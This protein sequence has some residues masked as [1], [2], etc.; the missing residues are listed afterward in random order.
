M[1]VLGDKAGERYW[2]AFWQGER[3]PQAFRVRGG[4]GPRTWFYRQFHEIWK[5]H[6][7]LPRQGPVK[8]LEI[9]CA[10]S[11]WLVYFAR[12][13]GYT[14]AGLDYSAEGCLRTRALLEREGVAGEILHQDLFHPQPAHLAAF[15]VVFSNG[16]VEHF[17]DSAAVVARMA[18]YLRPAGLMITIVPNLTGWLGELQQQLSPEV[19]AVHT[20]L[21]REELA[22]AHQ[23]AGLRPLVCAYTAFL[24]FSVVNPG[25]GVP[26][27]RRRLILKGLKAAS[28]LAGAARR[29]CPRLPLTR[30]TAGYLVCLAKK[31]RAMGFAGRALEK[32]WEFHRFFPAYPGG[33]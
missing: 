28:V 13:W 23:Q 15:D 29:L 33:S 22:E 2:T 10:Q 19:M 20:P 11:R 16:V 21:T 27:R 25:P 30:L 14:V 1:S 9:G 32:N 12:E 5:S 4:S 24:H 17:E 7:P 26:P 6:L 3:L 18:A 31:P 8:L